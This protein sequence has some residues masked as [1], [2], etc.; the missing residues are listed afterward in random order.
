VGW[1]WRK[2]ARRLQSRRAAAQSRAL[3]LARA[4]A[5]ILVRGEGL[6]YKFLMGFVQITFELLAKPES[7][8]RILVSLVLGALRA[9]AA[10]SS[11]MRQFLPEI[12]RGI[13]SSPENE[14]DSDSSAA[15]RNRR[16]ASSGKY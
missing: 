4:R 9:N 12:H 14:I 3:N 5:R 1:T 8:R 7:L 2:L 10:I 6:L 11:L 13:T 16:S 15:R